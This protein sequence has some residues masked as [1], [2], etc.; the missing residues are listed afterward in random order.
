MRLKNSFYRSFFSSD[1]NVYSV[2]VFALLAIAIGFLYSPIFN[3]NFQGDD[4]GIIKY[5]YFNFQSFL[6]IE[7]M[8]IWL[9]SLPYLPFLPYFRPVLQL[10][11]IVDY[12][13]WGLSPLGYH[14]TNL[15]LHL[16]TSFLIFVLAWQ[17]TRERL[18]AAIAGLLF[19]IMPIHVEAVSWFA[20]HADGFGTL[21]YL[22]AIVFF[23]LFRRQARTVFLVISIVATM[24]SLLVKEVAVTVPVML[25]VFDFLYSRDAFRKLRWKILVPH[26]LLWIIVAVYLAVRTIVNGGLEASLTAPLLQWD[27]LSQLFV[28][29]MTDPI[30]T[31]MSSEI[32][33]A[34]IGVGVLGLWFFRERRTV[35]F[36]LTWSVVTVLPSLLSV[37]ATLFDR[38]LYLPSVGL[39]LSLANACTSESNRSTFFARVLA[40][41]GLVLVLFIYGAGLYSRNGEWARAAQIT[42][43][44]TAQMQSLHPT[45]PADARLVFVNV[46]VLVGGRQMQA[47]GNNL[48]SAMQLLYRNPRLSVL[49]SNGFPIIQERLDKTF[50]FEYD[51]RKLTERVDLVRALGQRN[52]CMAVSQPA[53]EWSFAN[54]AQ[55]WEAWRDL[56][57]F[58][59]RDGWLVMRAVGN[60]PY[61]A[62]PEIAIST[63]EIGDIEIAMRVR[64]DD[65][66]L[67]A[68]IY[69]LASSQQD[70]SPDL[71][72]S[73]PVRADGELHTYRV[74][75]A[76]K[77]Q[78]LEG[79]KIVRLR[80]DPTDAPADI[81]VKTITIYT[82]CDTLVNPQ[83]S[84][85]NK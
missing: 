55:G 67:T 51:R 32:R 20:A 10:F 14:I 48:P 76:Q 61:F 18:S 81:A 11:Y 47:F 82:H 46:P 56:S 19:A 8:R 66:A 1:W 75:I 80:I 13:A 33:W 60:D 57:D 5:M 38:Y 41:I 72:V 35:W 21:W 28:L 17:L 78:L 85:G 77:G 42:E 23:I 9:A 58:Q 25:T 27:Y 44:V 59:N 39:A 12:T 6:T 4:F 30:F 53:I 65:P 73:V 45:L 54:D 83:C 50:F 63:M 64:A 16:L 3:A 84:C 52:Q 22:V 69:W 40:P 74:D 36:G 37:N 7:G 34:L 29:G 15:T 68:Q 24:L 31:D 49:K 43:T 2:A 70:F 26:A 62:S 79:D 71:Q